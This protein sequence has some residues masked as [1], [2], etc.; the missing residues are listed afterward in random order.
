MLGARRPRSA[1]LTIQ[2]VYRSIM[3]FLGREKLLRGQGKAPARGAT[4]ASVFYAE[5]PWAGG[6][7]RSL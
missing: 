3:V 6:C 7:G 1:G 4:G 5:R 2:R